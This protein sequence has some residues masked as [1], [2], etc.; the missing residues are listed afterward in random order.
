MVPRAKKNEVIEEAGRY[1]VYVT[2][3]ATEGRANRAVIE[4]LADYFGL[5]RSQIHLVQGEKSR[6]KFLDVEI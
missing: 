4:L 5:K 2:A 3:P 1:K 6:N